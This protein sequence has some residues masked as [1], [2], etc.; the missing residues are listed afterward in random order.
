VSPTPPRFARLNGP[1]WTYA[2]AV[3]STIRLDIERP[4]RPRLGQALHLQPKLSGADMQTMVVHRSSRPQEPIDAWLDRTDVDPD[5]L[6]QI[7]RAR[8]HLSGRERKAEALAQ[9][10]RS[11]PRAPLERVLSPT[12]RAIS[13]D[14]DQLQHPGTYA[15]TVR[16]TARGSD[17]ATVERERRI[18]LHLQAEHQL[19]A[20]PQR[21]ASAHGLD[22]S[23]VQNRRPRQP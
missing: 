5:R 2:L 15:M 22:L 3:D 19:S 7:A 20:E 4:T 10:G 8:P 17:G 1:A 21:L 14:A 13:I 18:E 11:A 9:A 16:A 6:Q 23:L 12:S